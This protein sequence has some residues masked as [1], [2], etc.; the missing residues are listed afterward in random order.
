MGFKEHYKKF[1]QFSKLD[2][3]CL[4]L[5]VLFDM[6]RS[7]PQEKTRGFNELYREL[8]EKKKKGEIKLG[9]TRKT[10]SLHLKHLK[11]HGLIEV[12]EDQTSNLKFK[13]CM[14]KASKHWDELMDDLGFMRIPKPEIILK[15]FK[16][17]EIE[18]LTTLLLLRCHQLVIQLFER[19]ISFPPLL[20]R[21][22]RDQQYEYIETIAE[23]YQSRVFELGKNVEASKIIKRF[24][25][26]YS[27]K[28]REKYSPMIEKLI[29]IQGEQK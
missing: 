27:E 16:N 24:D 12:R 9:F 4:I 3:R 21:I 23:N 26:Y 6:D 19:S 28:M 17:L 13:P 29:D 2:E 8:R 7:E 1:E 5:L 18:Q 22:E 11:D 20:N 10:L 15:E 14:Y 25:E